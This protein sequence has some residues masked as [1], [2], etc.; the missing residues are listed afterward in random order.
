MPTRSTLPNRRSTAV[1]AIGLV[2]AA[3]AAIGGARILGPAPHAAQACGAFGCDRPG[4]PTNVQATPGSTGDILLTWTNTSSEEACT[5]FLTTEDGQQ[6]DLGLGCQGGFL[7]AVGQQEQRDV[8]ANLDPGHSYC[9]QAR[10]RDFNN[11]DP[12]DGNVSDQWSAAACAYAPF[13]PL[14]G[15]STPAPS[16]PQ[17][18]D[19][20]TVKLT[21]AGPVTIT[22]TWSAAIR[23]GEFMTPNGA[24]YVVQR[25]DGTN[26]TDVSGPILNPLLAPVPGSATMTFTDTPPASA[27]SWQTGYTYR[28]CA[29][30]SAGQSCST[31][32]ST[33]RRTS[34]SVVGEQAG[35]LAMATPPAAGPLAQ[36]AARIDPNAVPSLP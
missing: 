32:V 18:P 21:S 25:L 15:Q 13:P 16:V 29:G 2:L 12:Q 9:F 1:S 11:G 7:V 20:P 27:R 6:V 19:T 3:A 30:N 5:E 34:P 10:A 24:W 22:L 17:Q 33:Q 36:P 28:V 31:T 4:T 26:W 14:G 8:T 23:D 35:A